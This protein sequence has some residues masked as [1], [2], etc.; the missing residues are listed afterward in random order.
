MSLQDKKYSR[1]IFLFFFILSVIILNNFM[2][3]LAITDVKEL[4]EEAEFL[5]LKNLVSRMEKHEKNIKRTNFLKRWKFKKVDKVKI[6]DEDMNL[7]Y[8]ETITGENMV[9]QKLLKTSEKSKT[10]IEKFLSCFSSNEYDK[11][12]FS[13]LR[14]KI[15][16]RRFKYEEKLA[17]ENIKNMIS[18]VN[19]HQSSE[20]KEF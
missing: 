17:E 19:R 7:L 15:Q 4:Q 11:N 6:D 16:E 10:L 5:K 20:Q 18:V 1:Q 2:D 8:V 9:N 13:Q 3:G 14:D 12:I